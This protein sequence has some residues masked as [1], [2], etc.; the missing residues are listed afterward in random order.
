MTFDDLGN[1]GELIAAI[2]TVATL[3]YLSTQIRLSNKLAKAEASRVPSS[4]QN[5]VNAALWNNPDAV[6]AFRKVL[7]GAG[8]TDL[9]EIERTTIDL[10]V[11][12]VINIHEQIAREIKAGVLDSS[13]IDFGGAGV[14]TLP[15]FRDSW[16]FYRIYLSSSFVEDFE[17]RYSLEPDK[18]FVL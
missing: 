1:I 8:R 11:I 5:T 17:I 3:I 18:E 2:A 9:D 14:F 7:G 10:Y 13:S 4:D 12:S 15:Y 16:P 6:L